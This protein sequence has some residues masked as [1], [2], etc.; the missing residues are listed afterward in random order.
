MIAVVSIKPRTIPM[1]KCV[2]SKLS[3]MSYDVNIQSLNLLQYSFNIPYPPSSVALR[4]EA[5]DVKPSG[6]VNIVFGL[7]R[8]FL[9]PSF[10]ASA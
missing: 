1:N 5:F 2:I 6:E 7:L 10:L 3:S 9:I 4:I 8:A